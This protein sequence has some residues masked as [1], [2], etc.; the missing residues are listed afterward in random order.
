[1]TLVQA[2]YLLAI[3]RMRGRE[4]T[5]TKIAQE[6]GVSKPSVTSMINGLEDKRLLKKE[7]GLPLTG[8]GK[9]TTE[10]IRSKQSVIAAYLAR[11]LGIAPMEAKNDA[12]VLMFEMSEKFVD[13]LIRKIEK[14]A[15]RAKL[16]EFAGNAY[17]TNFQ[18]I[19]ADGIYAIPF[20]LLKKNDG[21]LSMGDKGLVH[22]AKLVVVGGY[23][24]ISL[25]ALPLTHKGLPGGILKGKLA[26]LSY[27]NGEEYAEA[28]EEKGR[29]AFPV[30]DMHWRYDQEQSMDFGV[31]QLKV[32]ASVG[33]ANM[34]ESLADLAVYLEADPVGS[35][36][37]RVS[38]K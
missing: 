27:W 14:D 4:R 1:M 30:M 25:H 36:K 13:S 19:L 16:E 17:L 18:G 6:L 10:E 24:L 31:L 5:V 23:G 20:R 12:L 34:P 15:A 11:E 37:I 8:Q 9:A 21:R 22:P 3:E 35:E 26:R 28:P 32:Q 29:Y 38:W 33:V 7:R 2:R